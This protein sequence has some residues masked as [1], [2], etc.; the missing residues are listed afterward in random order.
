VRPF[1]HN[2]FERFLVAAYPY[3]ASVFSTMGAFFLFGF[4]FQYHK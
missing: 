2:E 4:A 1:R 3:Y